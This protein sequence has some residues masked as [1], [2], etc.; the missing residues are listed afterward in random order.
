MR[1]Y[2]VVLLLLLLLSCS[3]KKPPEVLDA[4]TLIE[5]GTD[6]RSAL[7][8]IFPE[9]RGAQVLIGRAQITRELSPAGQPE[10]DKALAAAKDNGFTGEPP[11]RAPFILEQKLQG[12]TLRQEIR[13]PLSNDEIARILA[14]PASITTEAI[15]HWLP[16]AAPKVQE[17]F[18]L[19]IIWAATDA[20]RA[21][22][23][24]WQLTDGA[25]A[26]GWTH[27]TLPSGFELQR[28]DGGPVQV[29]QELTLVLRNE[30][31]GAVLEIDRKGDRAKLRYR[32][33]TFE[34]R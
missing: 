25:R 19:E 20:A 24:V 31:L 32:L 2:A 15:A 29:P 33:K 22:F 11:T 16:K 18:E 12:T 3:C 30:H 26:T 17:E 6:L 8:T 23:L 14:A 34:R 13:L 27:E 4:G 9:W 28:V 1:L 7:T 5:R 10:L 21:D